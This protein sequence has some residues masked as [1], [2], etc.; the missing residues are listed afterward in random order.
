[1]LAYYHLVAIDRLEII[2]NTLFWILLFSLSM[3]SYLFIY[4]STVFKNM[5]PYYSIWL[6]CH[7]FG[8]IPAFFSHP[9][10]RSS[11]V[12]SPSFTLHPVSDHFSP[13]SLLPS[14]ASHRFV[15]SD[16]VHAHRLSPEKQNKTKKML[17]LKAYHLWVRKHLC[18]P[19]PFL[20]SLSVTEL[21]LHSGEQRV[22]HKSTSP[23]LLVP[24]EMKVPTLGGAFRKAPKED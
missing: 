14:F 15:P 9:T 16:L 7:Q 10:A 2:R 4:M 22:Q 18:T 17:A 5:V 23:V 1:M 3:L 13:P 8:V 20:S 6:I 21:R 24:R 12:L 19:C 11:A